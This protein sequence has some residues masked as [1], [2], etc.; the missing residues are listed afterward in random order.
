MR[1]GKTVRAASIIG[2][3]AVSVVL[4]VGCSTLVRPDPASTPFL[5]PAPTPEA[6][7]NGLI[8][9]WPRSEPVPVGTSQRFRLYTHCGLDS[10]IDFAGRLWDPVGPASDG[11]GNPPAGYGNPFDDGTITLVSPVEAR[12]VSA[13]GLLLPLTVHPGPKDVPG[14][15]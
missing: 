12:F 15:D 3:V 6:L 14:C 1:V 9:M 2:L 10:V 11:S 8:R 13:A 5:R 4:A 7:A